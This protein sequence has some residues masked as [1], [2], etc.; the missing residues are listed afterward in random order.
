MKWITLLAVS[1]LGI[2]LIGDGIL[3]LVTSERNSQS[4]FVAWMMILAGIPCLVYVAANFKSTVRRK[5]PARRSMKW[6]TLLT[7]SAL[8]CALIGEGILPLT[9]SGRNRQD[10]FVGWMMILAGIPCLVFVAF[11]IMA[12]RKNASSRH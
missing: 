1:A 10:D 7:V 8:G 4:D 3:P 2:E 5:T 6:L 12:M 9:W 11:D